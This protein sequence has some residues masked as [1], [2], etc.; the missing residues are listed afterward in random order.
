MSGVSFGVLAEDDTDCAAVGVLVRRAAREVSEAS[1]GLK[2]YSGSG[3]GKLRR[4]AEPQMKAMAR[5]GCAAAILVHDL[6][7]NP[8]NGQLNDEAALR[9]QLEAIAAP[10]GMVRLICIPVEEIEAWFWSDPA[11]VEEIG[12]GKGKAHPSPHLIAKPKEAL[13]KLSMAGDKKPRYST[14]DNLKLAEKLD[15]DLCARRCRAFHQL[16]GF[17]HATVSAVVGGP[18]G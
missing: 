18:A 9:A 3:C 5:E 17:V 2:K 14:N 10:A 1:I 7:R 11:V 16:R 12:R 4:K 6:D 8:D 13:I 15:L